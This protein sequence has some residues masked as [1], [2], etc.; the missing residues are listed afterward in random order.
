MWRWAQGA[1]PSHTHINIQRSSRQRNVEGLEEEQ[2][3][4]RIGHRVLNKLRHR[5]DKVRLIKTRRRTETFLPQS[6][7]REMFDYTNTNP[8]ISS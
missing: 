8:Q 1:P 2:P 4:C 5:R 3:S 6:V 7:R